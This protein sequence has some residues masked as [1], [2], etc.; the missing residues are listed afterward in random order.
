MRARG[1]R[2]MRGMTRAM[3]GMDDGYLYVFVVRGS[4]GVVRRG[5]V[6]ARARQ[7]AMG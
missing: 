6:G 3:R 1:R 7:G 2:A 5:R 4:W